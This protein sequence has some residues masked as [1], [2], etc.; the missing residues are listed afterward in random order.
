MTKSALL[1]AMLC[2]ASW[3]VIPVPFSPAVISLH[4]VVL[5]MIGL[6]LTPIQSFT[7]VLIY[8]LMGIVGLPV[9]SGG[10]SAVSKLLSPVGGYY[11]GFLLSAWL[12]SL[13][14][15]PK[16]FFW[17][18]LLI[19]L[20]A[21]LLVQHLCAVVFAAGYAEISMGEAFMSISLPF[22]PTDILKCIISAVAAV[23]VR[24]AAKT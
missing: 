1:I 15:G 8:L 6:L 20:T 18:Y 7:T 23:A 9:F 4:T 16:V 10:T 19:L 17:R 2:A 21:G 24:K 12:I 3:I 14:K 13:S 5:S 11:I 22:L